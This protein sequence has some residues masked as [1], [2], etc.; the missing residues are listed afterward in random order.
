MKPYLT[1]MHIYEIM[2]ATNNAD[3]GAKKIFNALLNDLIYYKAFF[4]EVQNFKEDINNGNYK[5]I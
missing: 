1:D 4:D 3:S 5:T 2:K